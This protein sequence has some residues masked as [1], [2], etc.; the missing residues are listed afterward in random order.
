MVKTVNHLAFALLGALLA[1]GVGCDGGT[2][3]PAPLEYGGIEVTPRG[4]A[5][6][7]VVNGALVVS[8]LSGARSG[9][10]TIAGDPARLDVETDPV[11]IPAGGRFGVV[12]DGADGTALAEMFNEAT[13]ATRFAMRF[14]F[15]DASG[16]TAVRV[17]YRLGGELIFEIPTLSLPGGRGIS[18]REASAG[19]AEGSSGSVHVIRGSDGKYTVVSD[20]E[21]SGSR[22]AARNGCAGFVVRPPVPLPPT[23]PSGTLCADWVEV[24]P[25]D[26]ASPPAAR[27]S[28]TARGVGAFTVRGLSRR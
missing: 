19:D 20:A 14:A 27:A 15:A 8:G 7:A 6:L 13:S 24:T 22:P 23:Y 16:V 5:S 17:G 18:A 26:G 28:V 4:D 12:V 25:L 1:V 21:G 3:A 11:A 9:G 2:D 10:F